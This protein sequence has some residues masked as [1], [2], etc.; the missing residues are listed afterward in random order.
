MNIP[1]FTNQHPR[2]NTFADILSRYVRN[3]HAGNAPEVYNA[4]WID[5]RTW[6]AIISNP[7]RP[8]AKRTAVQFAFALHL[9]RPEVDELLLSA[10]YALSPV[11][12]EDAIF[13]F[14]IGNGIFDLF[15]VNDI[16][17]RNGLKIFPPK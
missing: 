4:A 14:C 6:S 16:L 7:C 8:V 1:H 5:R 10:G 9:T 2:K 3:R 17:Y 13:A 15:K 12:A 11:V